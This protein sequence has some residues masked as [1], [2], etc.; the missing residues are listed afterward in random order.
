MG[1]RRSVV[2]E[3]KRAGSGFALSQQGDSYGAMRPLALLPLIFLTATGAAA[4]SVDAVPG[5]GFQVERYAVELRPDLATAAVS[6]TETVVIESTSTRLERI[7]FNINALQIEAAT[8]DGRSITVSRSGD[9]IVFI[10]PRSVAKGRKAT[11]RFRF[12][13][14]PRRGVTKAPDGLYTGYF[15]CDWMVCLQDSPGDKAYFALDLVLPD[16]TTSVG[17]GRSGAVRALGNG[18]ELHRWRSTRPWSP[19]VFAFAAGK[20]PLLRSGEFAFLDLTG[21]ADQA[22]LRAQ[23][24]DIAAFLSDKAGLPLPDQRYTQVIVPGREAQEAAGFSLIGQAELDR[25]RDHPE[26]AWIVAHEMA[27]QW[28]GNLVTC[29]TW[30]DFWLNEG[31]ATFMVAAWKEQRF[32]P[33]A[34]RAELDAAQRRLDRAREAGF[35][36]P[37]TWEGKYPSLNLKRAVHYSKGA[38][39]LAKLRENLGDKAFWNGVR[40]Y[41]RRHAGGTVTSRDFQRAMEQAG[42]RDLGPLFAEW[43]YG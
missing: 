11:L 40:T 38:L 7:V 22:A 28:W 8:V 27:H 33:T 35:D 5:K 34:Y 13:G 20:S 10:L 32:G 4:P 41:T 6:G 17:V 18:L 16:G 42:G 15:A 37:L 2:D 36:K 3:P 12:A 24:A 14:T 30:R 39:F 9:V 31:M 43:V 1:V 29:A 26:E 19:Y 23:T 25:E 21:K